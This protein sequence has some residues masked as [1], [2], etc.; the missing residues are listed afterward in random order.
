MS[1]LLALVIIIIIMFIL[2]IINHKN[3]EQSKQ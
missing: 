3:A 2:I 1:P